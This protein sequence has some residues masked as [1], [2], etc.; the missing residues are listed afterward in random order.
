[1]AHTKSALKDIRKS[2]KSRL[3][4]QVVRGS[5]KTALKKFLARTDST[6]VEADYS[7]VMTLV[8]KAAHKGVI[9]KN[10]ASRHKSQ[11]DRKL[12]TLKKPAAK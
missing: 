3:V 6:N 10:A 7:R 12:S 11:I 8:D 5:Y 9:H 1:M 2:R 4:N